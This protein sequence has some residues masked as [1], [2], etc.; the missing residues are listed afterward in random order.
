M[1]DKSKITTK[2]S[3]LLNI[4]YQIYVNHLEK[5]NSISFINT[6]T[7]REIEFIYS[8]ESN[9]ISPNLFNKNRFGIYVYN[10]LKDINHRGLIIFTNYIELN[11]KIKDANQLTSLNYYE[12][13]FDQKLDQFL[14][15]IYTIFTTDLKGV[16]EGREWIEVDNWHPYK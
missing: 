14:D 6:K 12:G 3:F 5:K 9:F 15:F 16:I 10:N 13:T 7:D 11:K 8:D 1:L 2:L 4:G